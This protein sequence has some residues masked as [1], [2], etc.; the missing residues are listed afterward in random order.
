MFKPSS[1]DFENELKGETFGVRDSSLL[2][3]PLIRFFIFLLFLSSPS[4][5]LFAATI[6]SVQSGS[7]SDPATW[8]G[9]VPG[10]SDKAVIKH[11]ITLSGN[12]SVGAVDFGTS[13]SPSTS[14]GTLAIN[15][16]K[17]IVSGDVTFGKNGQAHGVMTVASGASFE[18]G[19]TVKW[20]QGATINVYGDFKAVNFSVTNGNGGNFNVHSSGVATF[21]GDVTIGSGPHNFNIDGKLTIQ[22]DLIMSGAG[23]L[24]VTASGSMNVQNDMN[25]AYGGMVS[26]TGT[27][28]AQGCTNN[29]CPSNT[30]LPVSLLSFVGESTGEGVKLRWKTASELDN[31]YFTLEQSSDGINFSEVARIS[32]AGRTNEPQKYEYLDSYS[33]GANYYKLSQTDYDGTEVD[34][35][36]VRVDKIPVKSNLTFYPNPVGQNRTFQVNGVTADMAWEVYDL[37]G[38]KRSEGLFVSGNT[39]QLTGLN[40][41]YYLVIILEHNTTSTHKIFLQ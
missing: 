34:L 27:I 16:G 33:I 25:L 36:A 2:V 18:S 32:G 31:D 39:I 20:N 37:A 14:Y 38:I 35:A 15:S 24:D 30:V 3:N 11:D 10:V 5:Y 21:T 41:G 6:T 1:V 4:L 8:G 28:K 12:E 23:H 17:L 7:W 9:T 26:G 40:R 22:H 19:G 13:W 29:N